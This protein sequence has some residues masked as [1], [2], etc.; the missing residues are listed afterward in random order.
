MHSI[1]WQLDVLVWIYFHLPEI[2]LAAAV[3]AVAL[4]AWR[5]R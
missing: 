3:G 1:P 2:G 4:W 5:R